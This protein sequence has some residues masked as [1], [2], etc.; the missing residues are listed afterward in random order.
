MAEYVGELHCI[1]ETNV[2]V[3]YCSL[4]NFYAFEHTIYLIYYS[5]IEKWDSNEKLVQTYN[6]ENR[7]DDPIC[8]AISGPHIYVCEP[9]YGAVSTLDN[10]GK[11]LSHFI[12]FGYTTRCYTYRNRLYVFESERS[13]EIIVFDTVNNIKLSSFDTNDSPLQGM[14]FIGD[15]IYTLHFPDDNNDPDFG[16]DEF[17]EPYIRMHMYDL[18]GKLIG[19]ESD[20]IKEHV[21]SHMHY[22][23][24]TFKDQLIITYSY[25]TKL[26]IFSPKLEFI[27]SV[28]IGVYIFDICS[29][30][31]HLYLLTDQNKVLTF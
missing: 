16:F 17:E 31:H 3:H 29:D 13:D 10:Q 28:D 5:G 20:S 7:I 9:K 30:E 25:S 11:Y 4:R 6:G 8:M 26:F 22:Y 14:A 27:K 18:N 21:G 23:M 1:K 15:T 12:D 19:Q 24:A 2:N